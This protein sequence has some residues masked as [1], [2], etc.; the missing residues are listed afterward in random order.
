MPAK[1]G[2]NTFRHSGQ[3][4]FILLVIVGAFPSR[5]RERGGTGKIKDEEGE[6]NNNKY[7][8]IQCTAKEEK[9]GS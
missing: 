6:R 9:C 1:F 2:C 4:C 5:E 3:N 8:V 7:R